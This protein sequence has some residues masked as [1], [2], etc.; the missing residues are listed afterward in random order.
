MAYKKSRRG[1]K[2]RKTYGRASGASAPEAREAPGRSAMDELAA[3]TAATDSREEHRSGDGFTP[4]PRAI[5]RY[6]RLSG[7]GD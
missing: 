1:G 5:R 7:M 4:K 2:P 3:M 6:E